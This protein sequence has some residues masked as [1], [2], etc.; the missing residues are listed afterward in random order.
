MVVSFV[1]ALAMSAGRGTGMGLLGAYCAQSL[2]VLPHIF[3]GA[4]II[5]GF[6]I[7]VIVAWLRGY[8]LQYKAARMNPVEALR[9][10]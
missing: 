1:I 6:G 4:M 8:I 7:S 10:E 3:A 9:H 2:M 5:V